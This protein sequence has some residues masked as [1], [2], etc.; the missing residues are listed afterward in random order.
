MRCRSLVVLTHALQGPAEGYFIRALAKI[1]EAEGRHV[2]LH[3]GLAKAPPAADGLM[4]HV[5]LTVTPADYLAAALPY[6]FRFNDRAGDIGKQRV[7]RNLVTPD[8]SYRGPVIV[9]TEANA[10]GLPERRIADATEGRLAR[11][12]RALGDR[13]PARW[14][15]RYPPLRYPHFARKADVPAWVWRRQDLVVERL[16]TQRH[17]EGYRLNSA[18]FFGRHWIVSP[19]V[20]PV[21]VVKYDFVTELLPLHETVP[22]AVVEAAAR[23][24]LDWGKIDYVEVDGD[25][26]VLDAN[27]TPFLGVHGDNDRLRRVNACL[28]A[29]LDEVEPRGLPVEPALA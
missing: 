22:S 12:A 9:K 28:A 16:L 1:W 23:L 13:L 18:F 21:P 14:V 15:H 26:H 7:S 19:C 8:D 24:G 20:A 11:V 5:D 29:G 25:A 17:G 27:R 4:V 2:T 3:Q 6:A 10:A